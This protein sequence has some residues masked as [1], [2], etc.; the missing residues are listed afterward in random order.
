MYIYIFLNTFFSWQYDAS[1]GSSAFSQ[2]HS[3][4]SSIV[5]YM[6]KNIYIFPNY[7]H[8]YRQ[9]VLRPLLHN[10]YTISIFLSINFLFLII[11]R[12]LRLCI[13][14]HSSF[15][16]S[17]FFYM[18]VL[19]LLFLFSLSPLLFFLTVTRIQFAI[20][21]LLNCFYGYGWMDCIPVNWCITSFQIIE[22]ESEKLLFLLFEPRTS[23]FDSLFDLQREQNKNI[24]NDAC[25][26]SKLINAL[27]S[28]G[29]S[30]VFSSSVELLFVELLNVHII[31]K[32]GNLFYFSFENSLPVLNMFSVIVIASAKLFVF[33]SAFNHCACVF[34]L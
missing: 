23:I 4:Q 15:L 25:I 28:N 24:H 14:P 21:K 9:L 19:F 26:L 33:H 31:F 17:F 27:L 16:H 1:T 3:K 34:A 11:K 10:S 32:W 8:V 2:Q 20:Q 29:A 13:E 5:L 22:N 30:F 18:Y 6:P 12:Y 7:E